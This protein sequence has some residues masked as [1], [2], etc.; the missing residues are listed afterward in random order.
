MI[1]PGYAENCWISHKGNLYTFHNFRDFTRTSEGNDQKQN[2]IQETVD[3]K[4]L[5]W[6]DMFICP[7][8]F[9]NR[10]AHTIVRFNFSDGKH[11]CLSVESQLNIWEEYNFLKQIIHGY[12]I[13]YLRWTDRDMLNL[14]TFRHEKAYEYPVHLN[15]TAIKNLFI[16]LIQE[17]NSVESKR[18]KYNLFKNNCTTW[19]RKVARHHLQIPKWNYSLLF[20]WYLPKFLHDLGVIKLWEKKLVKKIK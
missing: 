7:F 11:T 17:T 8:M 16:D 5:V 12:R 6:L 4:K 10:I 3:L 2:W 15:S 9:K 19:L 18:Q 20:G 13:R 1:K 14:R